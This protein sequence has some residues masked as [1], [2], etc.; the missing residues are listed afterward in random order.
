MRCPSDIFDFE[1]TEEV[2]PLDKG[3]I[4]QDR[5]VKAAHFGLRVKSPGYNLFFV[6]LTG[7]GRTTY[8]RKIAHEVALTDPTPYDWCYVY[9]FKNPSRPI[10]LFF[11]PGKGREFVEDIRELLEELK[12]RIPKAFEGEEFEAKKRS[13][14]KELQEEVNRLME[15]LNRE[16]ELLGFALKRTP[17][18]FIN[19]PLIDGREMTQEEFNALPPEK[20]KELEA[21]SLELHERT[22]QVMKE[23]QK[24]ERETRA[25]MKRLER[26]LCVFVIGGLF[27]DLKEK[28]IDLP[29]V[30]AFL[31]D[32]M[33]DVV[34]HLHD[35]LAT[36]EGEEAPK[37]HHP[38]FDRYRVNLLVDNSRLQGAPVV[39]ESNPTYY[40]LVG[41][42][43]YEQRMGFLVTD[44]TK[45]KAGAIHRANGGY[46]ILNVTDVLRNFGAWDALKRVL[47]TGEIRIE[48]IAEH[49]GLIPMS[50]L[51]PEPI[52]VKVK[53]L[54]IG[55]PLI[56]HLL[57][58][59]DEDFKK[60]FK[61]K[62]DF[63]IDMERNEENVRD[64]CAFISSYCREEGLLHC[65]KTALAALIDYSSELAEDQ[66]KLTTRFSEII[67][68]LVEA[69]AWAR[70]D[71]SRY[72]TATHVK[73]AIE[74]KNYRENKY[75]ERLKEM[76]ARDQIIVETDGKRVG[77]INGL[78][79]I[80]LGDYTFGKPSRITATVHLGQRGVV[81]IERES[82]MSGKI[83]DK[84][85][86]ILSNYMAS[87]YAKDFSLTLSA[88][89]CF[90]QLYEGVEGDSASAAELYALLSAISEI[91]LRQD[92]AITGSVDQ[93]GNIQPIGGVNKKIA[94][95]FDFCKIRG[96]TGKQGVIIPYRNKENL[97]LRED[98]VEAVKRGE[99]H[100]YA[101]KTIDE[102]IEILTGLKPEDFHREVERK[103]KEMAEVLKEWGRRKDEK[104]ER[105]E[106]E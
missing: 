15:A 97:M 46:L 105:K 88:S 92:I 29:K 25:K 94:G 37:K 27:K 60:L 81:N 41:K 89:I 73:R 2:K 18:G 6:G 100:I 86:M 99:F 45:I 52:P 90:E 3:I 31:E 16:A 75:E 4:G 57:S 64:V 71:G 33:E 35:F 104:N 42:L 93:K 36:A 12:V 80:N 77:Q 22:M 54:L 82:R 23:V 67:P 96:L 62:V 72:I 49:V 47:K 44:F 24:L 69:D 19:V 79:I 84:G 59:F 78:A 65:D 9:N 43:E 56:Y 14:L 61:I 76:F 98:I 5:V 39:F 32:M 10:A 83:H 40:N 17:T 50:G 85:V 63:D 70:M 30:V 68:I 13:V 103:L 28:Y 55:S 51:V 53:V 8:A 26:E 102:G 74:E 66:K 95:F 38:S 48:N 87:R 21:R 1:T 91:P 34:D 58:I 106:E 7:T 20:K 11:P 101:I